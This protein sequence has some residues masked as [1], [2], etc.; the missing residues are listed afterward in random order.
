MKIKYKE[1]IKNVEENGFIINWLYGFFQVSASSSVV[2][3]I[4]KNNLQNSI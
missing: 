4:E 1:T 3:E 2:I